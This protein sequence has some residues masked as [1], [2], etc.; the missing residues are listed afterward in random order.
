MTWRSV[1]VALIAAV[2]AG[3]PGI[4]RAGAYSVFACADAA[5][6]AN[7]SWFL[8]NTAP[9]KVD[10]ADGCGQTDADDA[11][12]IR[13]VL[14]VSDS[15]V[16]AGAS[17]T[18]NAPAGTVVR[19]VSYS[20]WLYKSPDDN[21]EV[22]LTD[23]GSILETC[24][25]TYPA[26]SCSVGTTGGSRTAKV[27]PDTASISLGVRCAPNPSGHCGNGGTLHAVAAVLYGATVTLSDPSSPTLGGISGSLFSGG[28]VSGS[29]LVQFSASDNAGIRSARLYVDGVARPSAT[30]GCDFTYSVPC[31]D[32]SD[33]QLS[34]D[35]NALSD[36]SH[37]VQVAASD[38]AGNEVK[39]AAQTITVD[40]GAPGAPQGIAVAGGDGWRPSNSFDVSWIN[41]GNQVAPVSAAH[42][43]LCA[44]DGSGCRTPQQS[45]ADGIDRLNGISVPGTGEWEL[46]VWLE[47]A[48]GHS[49]AS[50]FARATLRYGSAPIT[51]SPGSGS[52]APAD[53][54]GSTTTSPNEQPLADPL[55]LVAPAPYI[56]SLR[57]AAGLRV[58]S[59]R[60]VRGR[61]VIRGRLATGATGALTLRMRV[62][63]RLIT[64]NRRSRGGAFRLSFRLSRRPRS[65]T[66]R[67]GGAP[68]FLAQSTSAR[69]R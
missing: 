43:Q 11:L 47:D 55:S 2:L 9:T 18:F 58:T 59:A 32:Q 34:L 30:F 20:R 8:A 23:D 5:T 17:W 51:P 25:I 49:D 33:A 28:Y 10:A 44:L 19:G 41:P 13:D 40:N 22:T 62:G 6:G 3:A 38:P 31:S 45:T 36:G 54:V 46:R 1:I 26:D 53:S 48:A 35:T 52:K 69:V 42:Y 29:R 39:S 14:A 57:R 65:V 60:F 21:W 56:G 67:Y 64:L 24:R 63:S 37:S 4:A 66:V 7:N 27:V 12:V 16:G 50:R 15:S 61:L 68:R